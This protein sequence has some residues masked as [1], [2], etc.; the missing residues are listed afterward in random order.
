[1]LT[2]QK[3]L[4]KAITAHAQTFLVVHTQETY[5]CGKDL[6]HISL[7]SGQKARFS[8]LLLSLFASIYIQK[9]VK[10]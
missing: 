3:Q 9:V 4:L 6:G 7:Q 10:M 5:K 1:V 2:S 8:E